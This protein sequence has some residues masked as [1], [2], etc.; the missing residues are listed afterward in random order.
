MSLSTGRLQSL[1]N[2]SRRVRPNRTRNA[3]TPNLETLEGR[4]LLV[5]IDFYGTITGSLHGEATYYS[6][7]IVDDRP[8]DWTVDTTQGNF[9]RSDGRIF[10]TFAGPGFTTLYVGYGAEVRGFGSRNEAALLAVVGAR[11]DCCAT[12]DFSE[13]LG[14]NYQVILTPGTGVGE[15]HGQL[16]HT[17]LLTTDDL[18][19]GTSESQYVRVGDTIDR[20]FFLDNG[21]SINGSSTE[22]VKHLAFRVTLFRE[23][24][25]VH[26]ANLSGPG[27]V[28][29]TFS[30]TDLE[31]DGFTMSLFR[32][33]SPTGDA[34]GDGKFDSDNVL[35]TTKGESDTPAGVLRQG[36]ITFDPA[37]YPPDP[38]RPYLLV[39]ADPPS[40]SDPVG[41]ISEFNE[42][43]NVAGFQEPVCD[44]EAV[45]LGWN[46]SLTG[47]TFNYRLNNAPLPTGTTASF[48]WATG[49]TTNTIICE[50]APSV[51][52]PVFTPVLVTQTIEIP[53]SSLSAPPTARYLLAVV[54]P[55]VSNPPAQDDGLIPES[56]ATNNIMSLDIRPDLAIETLG[57]NE[58]GIGLVFTLS[59]APLLTPTTVKFYW[60][61]SL[62]ALDPW[63]PAADPVVIPAGIALGRHDEFGLLPEE[64]QPAPFYLKL[65][66]EEL[67]RTY[68]QPSEPPK[69][70]DEHPK[71][72]TPQSGDIELGDS[73]RS[74]ALSRCDHRPGEC[75]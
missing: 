17:V 20:S 47:I 51:A 13:T 53:N 35:L 61:P 59:A 56:V 46:T 31:E 5:A 14:M 75:G 11:S 26:S 74:A 54:D 49:T 37:Q 42:E 30:T 68:P 67:Y 34:D 73:E 9:D 52:I 6:T 23:N 21:G 64:I 41:A 70:G 72:K 36:T 48:Y 38:S 57:I 4:A 27:E 22:M 45:S 63:T 28:T 43:D 44:L 62:E 58:S 1:G 50:A 39:V 33:A 8:I 65:H 7:R 10:F 15:E 40:E 18:E 24:I 2:R 55:P 32:S 25:T 3:R 16:G 12:L 69:A 71:P 19:A 60:A 29:Y 66:W